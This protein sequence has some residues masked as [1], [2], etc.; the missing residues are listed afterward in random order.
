MQTHSPER[1]IMPITRGKNKP[2]SPKEQA[3]VDQVINKPRMPRTHAVIAAG[4]DVSTVASAQSL[5]SQLMAKPHIQSKLQNY[6]SLVESAMVNTV[7]EWGDADTPRKREIALQNAQFIHDK[8]H[9][10]ARQSVDITTTAV[11][12]NIDLSGTPEPTN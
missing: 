11:T 3:F 10:K 5:A 9:G 8:V 2:L 12:F 6:T 1:P 7:K 4:Y